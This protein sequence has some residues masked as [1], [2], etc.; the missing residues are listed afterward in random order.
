MKVVYTDEALAALDEILGYISSHYPTA[1]ALFVR[2]DGQR[3][4][5]RS[6]TSLAI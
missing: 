6:R 4:V 5:C 1:Y 2:I 3:C